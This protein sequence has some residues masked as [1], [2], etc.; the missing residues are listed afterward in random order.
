MLWAIIAILAIVF[1]STRLRYVQETGDHSLQGY[2][3]AMK[4]KYWTKKDTN[5]KPPC[6][7]DGN[8]YIRN[9][10]DDEDCT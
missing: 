1:F 2:F 10:D 4:E 8:R 6:S 9:Y 3:Q 7:K 5:Y